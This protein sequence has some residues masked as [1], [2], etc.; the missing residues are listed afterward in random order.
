[1]MFMNENRVALAR[2][3][4]SLAPWVVWKRLAWRAFRGGGSTCEAMTTDSQH[5]A[6]DG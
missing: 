6:A 1:M 2:Q 3:R 4:A 5:G